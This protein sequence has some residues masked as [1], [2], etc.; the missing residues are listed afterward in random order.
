[1]TPFLGIISGDDVYIQPDTPVAPAFRYPSAS[2]ILPHAL[3]GKPEVE[4][5]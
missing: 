3:L 5:V 2:S 4:K 1:M